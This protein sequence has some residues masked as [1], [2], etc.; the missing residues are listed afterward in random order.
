MEVRDLSA[1]VDW[2]KWQILLAALSFL[3][4]KEGPGHPKDTGVLGC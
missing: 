4:L 3:I 1:D 2:N